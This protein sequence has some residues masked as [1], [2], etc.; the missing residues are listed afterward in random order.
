MIRHRKAAPITAA[1][2]SAL[3]ALAPVDAFAQE[4]Q[5][6]TYTETRTESGSAVI[7]DEDVTTGSTLGANGATIRAPSAAFRMGL[8]RPRLNFVAEMLKSVE[9]L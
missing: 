8:V 5:E 2:A 3:F 9:A 4:K 6:K 1:F 7:F